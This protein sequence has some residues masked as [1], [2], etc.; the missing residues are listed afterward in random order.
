MKLHLPKLLL[1]AVLAAC[2][3]AYAAEQWTTPAFS[4]NKYTWTGAAGDNQYK[5]AA[6][7]DGG[8]PGRVNNNGTGAVL[9]FD[10]VSATVVN[11]TLDQTYDTSD[12]GGIV[13]INNSNVTCTMGRWAG[14]IYVEEG[15]TLSTSFSNELKSQGQ[16]DAQADVYVG[17]SLT[18]TNTTL[19]IENG[20]PRQYWQIDTHGSIDISAAT[21]ISAPETWKVQY[22]KAPLV[23]PGLSNTTVENRQTQQVQ[24]TQQLISSSVKLNGD[25][26]IDDVIVIDKSTGNAA[27][28]DSYNLVWGENGGLSISYTAEE[29]Q[30]A[31][32]ETSG[33]ITWKH[34]ASGWKVVDG[35]ETNT[36]FLNGD[37]VTFAGD[38]SAALEGHITVNNITVRPDV[39]YTVNMADNSSLSIETRRDNFLGEFDIVGGKDTSLHL[40]M[41][42]NAKADGD[43]RIILSEGSSV[44]AV[45]VDGVFAYNQNNTTEVA[46]NLR[47]ADLHL[48]QNGVLLLRNKLTGPVDANIGDIYFDGSV[49]ELRTYGTALNLELADNISAAGELRKTDGGSI[50]LQGTVTAAALSVNEGSLTLS[51]NAT[52]GNLYANT[53]GKV[54]L[55]GNVKVNSA[56][57][58]GDSTVNITGTVTANQL[59]LGDSAKSDVIIGKGGKLT[60]TGS[61]NGHNTSASIL[62]AHWNAGSTSKLLV[63]GGELSATNAEVHL[64][65][66]GRGEFEVRNGLANV[67]GLNFW[68][69]NNNN[70]F[71]GIFILGSDTGDGTARI[72]IG[73]S[74]IKDAGADTHAKIKV[75]LSNGIIGAT[76]NWSSQYN[77]DA[78][79]PATFTLTGTGTGTVFDTTDANDGQTERTITINNNL[80]GSGKLVK[81]GVGTLKVNGSMENFGGALEVRKGRAELSGSSA[82][83]VSNLTV[84]SGA[85]LSI[86]SNGTGTINVGSGVS[87]LSTESTGSKA[88]LQG[89]ASIMGNLDLSNATILT[90]NGIGE[91][92]LVNVTGNLVLPEGTLTLGGDILAKLADLTAGDKLGIFSVG[93]FTLGSES[94]TSDLTAES[95]YTLDSVFAGMSADYYLGYTVG[96]N[97]GGT[98]YIGK[99]IPEPT[100]ATLSLLALAG[101][102]ARRRRK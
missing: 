83:T 21:S 98:V 30:A 95:G 52:V 15:S 72:N 9:T 50:D 94:I 18:I 101:L 42:T 49:G 71:S 8:T 67:K 86:G 59:R 79:T 29:Y 4:T 76:A 65:W 91:G 25:G 43:G 77:S 55:S 68:G 78:S 63:D 33:D 99:V 62:L 85:V 61:E 54:D 70:T 23:T 46:S 34:G 35:D 96:N 19:D 100:T 32:L 82:L 3:T 26:L 87:T 69:N 66:D 75:T 6:N 80:A 58:V 74:G 27:A 7:W 64:S 92:S 24:F 93:S 36:T 89:G 97:G 2:G 11:G 45:Y 22:L 14:A 40:N 84:K 12:G 60:I 81:D 51:S 10:N 16:G 31:A 38:G 102:A 41:T 88:D 1:T 20:A 39:D 13:A 48:A 53:S 37:T 5:T 56:M 17:G 44:G 73:E 90:L 57:L 28:E 47:G